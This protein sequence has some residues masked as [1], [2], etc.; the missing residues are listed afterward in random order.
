MI[1]YSSLPAKHS[2]LQQTSGDCVLHLCLES[3]LEGQCTD[4]KLT[5]SIFSGIYLSL[6]EIK[7]KKKKGFFAC[8][9]FL[10][11]YR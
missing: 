3:P 2:F 11:T 6:G 8:I 7:K 5:T 9:F 4:I 10:G 1:I